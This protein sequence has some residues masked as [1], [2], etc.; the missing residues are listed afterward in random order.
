MYFHAFTFRISQAVR[1]YVNNEIFMIY[2]SDFDKA[3]LEAELLTI[4][5]LYQSIGVGRY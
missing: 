2:D 1:K 5:Q 3:E 4:Q